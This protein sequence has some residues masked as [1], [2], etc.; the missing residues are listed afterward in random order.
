MIVLNKAQ[1][2]KKAREVWFQAIQPC[3]KE[4]VAYD[5]ADSEYQVAETELYEAEEA[6]EGDC[7]LDGTRHSF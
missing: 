3:Y 2:R 4:D 1:A 7:I 6:L 5:L